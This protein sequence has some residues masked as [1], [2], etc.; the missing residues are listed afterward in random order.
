MGLLYKQWQDVHR[1]Q[2][3]SKVQPDEKQR[4]TW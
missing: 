4:K 2:I 3:C 1:K